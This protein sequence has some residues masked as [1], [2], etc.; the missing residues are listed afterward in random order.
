MVPRG[1]TRSVVPLT[2]PSTISSAPASV[3]LSAV[4]PESTVRNADAL[5]TSPMAVPP[6]KMCSV[7]PLSTSAAL[8][9][10]ET[11]SV[12]PLSV[13]PLAVPPD[14]ISSRPLVRTVMPPLD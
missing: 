9:S 8:S 7:P 13:V 10:P 6:E 5:R 1:A 3:V 11:Y 2:K 12:P 4:P 14:R